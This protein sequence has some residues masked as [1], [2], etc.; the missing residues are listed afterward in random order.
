MSSGAIDGAAR[1]GMAPGT[2]PSVD[3]AVPDTIVVVLPTAAV[4]VITADLVAGA[5]V[6]VSVGLHWRL[7][8]SLV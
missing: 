7:L 3:R 6:D 1:A 2:D 8:L 4:R 5:V